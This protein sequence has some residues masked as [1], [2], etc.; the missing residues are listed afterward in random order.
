[1]SKGSPTRFS[2]VQKDLVAGLVVFLVA[3]P[4][5][6]GI[7]LASFPAEMPEGGEAIPKL[8][9]GLLAGII[10]GLV[11]GAIS[12]SQTS[13]SGPA[14]G[15]TAVVAAQISALGSFE[16][17]LLA[18][19]LAG[20]LQ[21]AMG[22]ARAGAIA[23]FF[24]TSVIKGL[25]AAI[26]VI[27]ILKQTPHLFGH[28]ADLEGEMSFFQPDQETTFSE[29]GE[30]IG[31]L[32]PGATVIGVLT[33]AILFVWGWLKSLKKSPIPGPL[34]VVL[35]GGVLAWLL[36]LLVRRDTLDSMWRIGSSHLVQVPVAKSLNEFTAYF[37]HP[38]WSAWSNPTIYLAAITIAIVA[39]LETLLNIEAV[40][41][42]D[43]QQ[44]NSPPNRELV[45][46]GVGNMT[47]GLVGGLPVTSV[48]VRSSVNVM[49]GGQTRLSTLFHG[50]LLITSI[51]FFPELINRIPL[52]CL[53]AILIHTGLKLAHPAL[54]RTMWRDGWSQFVPF[55]VTIGAIVG[56]DLLKGVLIG[57][58]VSFLFIL[59]RQLRYPMRQI[60][61]N[62]VAGK[63]LRIELPNQV[64]FLNRA[65]LTRALDSV[66]RDGHVLIDARQAEYID[67]DVMGLLHDFEQVTAPVRG[68]H[69]SLAGFK[70]HYPI[71]NRIQYVD[72]STQEVQEKLTPADVVRILKEG[73]D[74]FRSGQRL[75]RD[76]RRQLDAT[77]GGQFPL[78][79][80]LACI[81]SRVPVELVF[82]L[83]VGDVFVTRIAGNVT[84]DRVLGSIEYAC[85]VAGAK[86][87]LVMG[88]SS[89]GAVTSSL[90]L[91]L[92]DKKPSEA[93]PCKN[94]DALVASIQE[95]IPAIDL[96]RSSQWTPEE[97]QVSVNAIARENVRRSVQSV[98]DGS[99]TIAQ[100]AR[101]GDIDVLGGFYDIAS[102]EVEFL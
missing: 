83:G 78:A 59:Y 94:L 18:V 35:V 75:S 53:A 52:A 51:A 36:D 12:K 21:I 92:A 90:D 60:E 22:L 42:I 11:V 48:I 67:P 84:S 40:D 7:A 50:A 33:L 38:D 93:T 100:M 47:A 99:A 45:A 32:H 82:D 61:E 73:N 74:R 34:V 13:V 44:R 102:G 46:Q 5:C 26:G 70:D 80:V 56:T 89:C 76:L 37:T 71:N 77:A 9:T 14:A 91:Y 23:A 43:P 58:G 41:R 66:S 69:L 49:S 30:I 25:L 24:P 95:A 62:H 10:G 39:S 85:A 2:T 57:L 27:L 31:H 64:N 16:A 96:S 20:A 19:V 79:I 55:V 29:L 65:A 101:R 63:V 81:D 88:H 28:D 86:L 54:F 72:F 17:F 98:I 1:M 87:V 3:L 4:L 8:A 97:K 6:L 15:L 68:V